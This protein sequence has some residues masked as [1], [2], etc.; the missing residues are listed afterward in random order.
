VNTLKNVELVVETSVVEDVEDLHPD[1]C[2]E[3]DSVQLELLV[4]IG[5][6]VAENGA[7]SEVENKDGSELVNIL[8]HDLLPHLYSEL[9]Y[10]RGAC[11]TGMTYGCCDERLVLALGRT[12]QDFFCRRVGGKSERRECV[13]DK[14][15]PEQLHRLEDGLRIV[16]INSR[17]KGKQDSG[18]IDGDLELEK[19]A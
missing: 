7:T 5:E 3:D 18:D 12:V 2:V 10:D 8:A 19:L 13:H 1:E 6:I 4:G 11:D 16:V 15:D 9:V 17:N 14:V